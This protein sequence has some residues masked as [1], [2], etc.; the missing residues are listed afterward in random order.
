ML[1]IAEC[2]LAIAECTLAIAECTLAIAECTLAIGECTLAIGECTLA[3][4]ECTLAR[5]ACTIGDSR[6]SR[7]RKYGI[8]GTTSPTNPSPPL[9]GL[10]NVHD[11]RAGADLAVHLRLDPDVVP[12]AFREGV[13]GG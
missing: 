2:T 10:R 12:P 7:S 9:E 5:I 3:I 8:S 11:E 6:R 4:A 13:G 1:A